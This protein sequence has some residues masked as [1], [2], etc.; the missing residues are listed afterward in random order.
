MTSPRRPRIAPHLRMVQLGPERFALLGEDERYL[1]QG[2]AFA[3]VLPLVDGTR[4]PEEIALAASTRVPAAEAYYALTLAAQRGYIADACTPGPDSL[5]YLAAL[6]GPDPGAAARVRG[7]RLEVLALGGL[8]AK[9][10]EQALREFGMKVAGP[11]N[12]TVVLVTDYL[13][14][15]IEGLNAGFRAEGRAW[16][17]AKP[18]GTR[19]WIGPM[20]GGGGACWTCLAARLRTNR[21]LE[22]WIRRQGGQS[23]QGPILGCRG[24]HRL[25]MLM[26]AQQILRWIV[27]NAL[28]GDE[29]SLVTFDMRFARSDAHAIRRRPQCPSCGHGDWMKQ[30]IGAAIELQSRP[31]RYRQGGYRIASA[32]NVLERCAHLVDSVTGAVI[33]LEPARERENPLLSVMVGNYFAPPTEAEPTVEQLA[34]CSLGKGRT[35]PQSMVSALGEAIERYSAALQGDEPRILAPRSQLVDAVDPREVLLV[36]E[37]Q[38]GDRD[39]HNR[40]ALTRAER[41]PAPYPEERALH[42]TQAWSLTRPGHARYIPSAMCYVGVPELEEAE[43]FPYD[44]NGDAAGSC[45][46][47]AV[48]QAL[49]EVVE[50]DAVGIWWYNR[51]SRP[52]VA[53]EAFED[54][55]LEKLRGHYAGQGMDVWL[56][57]V[58]TDLGIPTFV[59]YGETADAERFSIGCG[60]HL[61]PRLAAERALTEFNQLH[62]PTG[63]HPLPWKPREHPDASFLRPDLSA[64]ARRYGPVESFDDILHAVQFVLAKLEAAGLEALALNRTRPDLEL[65]VVRVIVPGL[66]HFWRRLGPGRLYTVPVQLGWLSRPL[67]ESELNPVPLR[68]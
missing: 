40:R 51:L 1:L 47:E 28:A 35:R 22:T 49:L 21:P 66:R 33:A 39:I 38:Y 63:K 58:T 8:D 19:A 11:S 52:A 57:D 45:V 5:A 34:R 6:D 9:P 48:L 62:D 43:A 42:W 64:P 68:L 30:Q 24:S 67:L 12:L 13:D 44:S 10:M 14:P 56:L 65:S 26:A 37:T 18:T 36:S 50:R 29:R 41:V 46:E 16:V 60:C 61:D 25:M 23:G 59:A 17:M 20:I 7:T 4:T 54:D 55:F 53:I 31:I 32:E 3:S 15:A 2:D 27:G